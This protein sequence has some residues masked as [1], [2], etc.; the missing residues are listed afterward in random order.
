MR[1]RHEEH[2]LVAADRDFQQPLFGRVKRERAEVEA[3]LLDFDGDLPR[4]HA[5]HV[6]GDVGI[7]LAEARDERQQ[8]VHGGLV[9]ADEHASAAEVAQF[10]D[11]RFGFLGEPDQPLSVVL[12]HLPGLGQRAGLGR[13]VE[14]LLAELELQPPHGLADRRLRAVHLG[15]GARKTALL[16]HG[17]KHLQGSEV[18]GAVL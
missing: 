14:Q 4:R 1:R 18:H 16:R 12:E 8:G 2:E 9:G 10:A 6:D 3:A 5:A 17:Q 7:P 11:R 13:P 15:G